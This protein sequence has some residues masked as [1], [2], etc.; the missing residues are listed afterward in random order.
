MEPTSTKRTEFVVPLVTSPPIS[1]EP[2]FFHTLPFQTLSLLR[3]VSKTV[4]PE[5]GEAMAF[6]CAVVRRGGRKPLV[7]ESIWTTAEAT[8]EVA[9]TPM[10]PAKYAFPVV[11]APPETVRPPACAPLPMVEEAVEM[12]PAKVERPETFKVDESDSVPAVRTPMFPFVEKRLVLDAVVEKKLVVVAAVP[13]AFTKVRLVVDATTALKLEIYAFV[14]V[15]L[16]VVA[17]VKVASVAVKGV[18]VKLTAPETVRS[19]VTV[20]VAR[21][22]SPEEESVVAETEAPEIEPPEMPALVIVGFVRSSSSRC[23]M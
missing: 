17:L 23:S 22:V 16:V 20:V 11:V 7:V 9:P 13:V 19:P 12:N 10:V 14:E 18:P 3:S 4:R 8:L 2:T 21:L 1:V 6:F 15:E 5:A